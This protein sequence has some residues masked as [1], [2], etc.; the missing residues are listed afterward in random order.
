MSYLPKVDYVV[1]RQGNFLSFCSKNECANDIA[2]LFGGVRTLK[3][4]RAL[5]PFQIYNQIPNLIS[6]VVIGKKIIKNNEV[7]LEIKEVNNMVR[8]KFVKCK[9]T[10]ESIDKEYVYKVLTGHVKRC[11]IFKN[12]GRL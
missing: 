6:D 10:G 3:C 4:S 11:L 12:R 7:Y 8:K 9:N 5:V 1:I 2:K